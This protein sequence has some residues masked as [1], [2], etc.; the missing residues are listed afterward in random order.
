MMMGRGRFHASAWGFIGLL[1]LSSAYG[2]APSSGPQRTFIIGSDTDYKP[3]QFI[4]KKGHATGFD[5]EILRAVA[6]IMKL[7]IRIQ[8]GPW[9]ELRRQL[10]LKQLDAVAGMFYSE[11]RSRSLDFSTP[12]LIVNHAV[13]I[14]K[15]SPPFSLEDLNDKKILVQRGDRMHDLLIARGLSESAVPVDS[16]FEALR[17]LARGQHDGA[18]LAKL[19]G[20]FFIHQDGLSNLT[21]SGP[22]L[23]PAQKCFALP[24]GNPALLASLNEGLFILKKTGRY[25]EI[26]EKW[27]G[28]TEP[29][30][31]SLWVL[32][33][34]GAWVLIPLLALL[35]GISF[36]SWMLKKQVNKRT[37]ALKREIKKRQKIAQALKQANEGLEF[38]VAQ[39]TE[40]LA[41]LSERLIADIAQRERVEKALQKAKEAAE[42]AN[43]AKSEF[44]TN[45]SHE[46]R[47]P[48]NG[49]LGFAQVLHN[50]PSLPPEHRARIATIRQ[51]GEYLLTLI[52]DLLDL[53]KIEAGKL[54]LHKAPFQF[55]EFLHGISEI[56]SLRAREKGIA[57]QLEP[58]TPLPDAVYGDDKRLRQILENLLCNGIKFTE[59]GKVSLKISH[60]QGIA[61]FQVEDTG[62]GIAQDDLEKIFLP[63]EQLKDYE[64]AR[65]GTGLGLAI[66][67]KLIHAMGGQLQVQS[68]V[69]KGSLFQ[70]QLPLPDTR[71]SA[72]L[73]EE[74][75]NII[76]YQG[77]AR[78]ILIVDDNLQNLA[79]LQGMLEPLHFQVDVAHNAEECLKK[80]LT[81]RPDAIL[82]DLI[83]PGLDGFEATR[84]LRQSEAGKKIA[85]IAVSA[86]A[87]AETEKQSLMAGCDAFIAKPVHLHCLLQCLGQHLHL[88]WCYRDRMDPGVG[89]GNKLDLTQA[90]LLIADDNEVNRLLL[91]TQLSYTGAAVKEAADGQQ[92][93][94]LIRSFP[95]DL[96]LLDLQMPLLN[97]LEIVQRLKKS[98]H[99]NDSTPIIAVTAHA[100]P[101]QKQAILQ[102]GF[103]DLLI[104]PV[105][106]EQI[107]KL[108]E[109]WLIHRK[110][111]PAES[112]SIQQ[113]AQRFIQQL[114]KQTKS[115]K[116]LARTLCQ[117][118]FTQLPE[119]QKKFE[120]ALT[121]EDF[122]TA[123]AL[124]HKI[125]G[126]ANLCDLAPLKGAAEKL[127]IA[128]LEARFDQLPELF[129]ALKAE[130]DAFLAWKQRVFAELAE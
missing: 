6:G 45:M 23:L 84:R 58:L 121:D 71:L 61:C 130:I 33:K 48:L 91:K 76:G 102:A 81:Y 10:E 38:R 97:G 25:K 50:A 14:R 24:K 8:T 92:A 52:S 16:A 78:R 95:F 11:E 39:R 43:R 28:I 3:Y 34:Y 64:M 88:T 5:V 18:L 117:T 83:L 49:I 17:L 65:E 73:A 75:K 46:L 96:I 105:R 20:L 112:K 37:A 100:S 42:A 63:F 115:N 57:F 118:L 86:N 116:V 26:H 109:H 124:V 107:R 74:E 36:I 30:P 94:E 21:S 70:V 120:K 98:P 47:T 29:S 110:N 89:S 54:E 59:K 22:P 126:S 56:F 40:E 15:D 51:C 123:Q 13:F 90:S 68:T 55:P 87:F 122:A 60:A 129:D 35:I 82:M 128:L 101:E 19:Q 114:L 66:S 119:Q 4:D 85:I 27:F 108:A 79:S 1:V 7:D 53:S 12:Y 125:H 69:G 127:E 9:S 103:C 31:F 80:A 44:L 111:A 104:K 99:P 67:K 77:K 113:S 32:L 93:I 41:K 106:D 62:I 2:N 72:A